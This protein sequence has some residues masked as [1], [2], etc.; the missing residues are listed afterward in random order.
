MANTKTFPQTE[1]APEATVPVT[2]VGP[3]EQTSPDLGPLVA[4]QRYQ[5]AADRAAYLCATH[6]DYWQAVASTVKE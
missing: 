2:Y 3:P 6:P 4:G 1:A 5:V